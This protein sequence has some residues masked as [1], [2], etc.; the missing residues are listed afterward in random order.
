MG[1]E[2]S[3]EYVRRAAEGAAARRRAGCAATPIVLEDLGRPE[4]R[5]DL[6]DRLA[7][8]PRL[9]EGARAAA[10]S[11]SEYWAEFPNPWVVPPRPIP[12]E[13]RGIIYGDASP[14][15]WAKVDGY[16]FEFASVTGR[17]RGVAVFVP[18]H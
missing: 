8:D 11:I 1:S 10:R 16:V 2:A 17:W 4:S 13:Q 9:P 14:L 15:C 12:F 6:W 5:T 18:T 3:E 7:C